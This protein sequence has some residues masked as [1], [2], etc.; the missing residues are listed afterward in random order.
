MYINRIFTTGNYGRQEL[1]LFTETDLDYCA[2]TGTVLGFNDIHIPT[3]LVNRSFSMKLG[4]SSGIAFWRYGLT[5]HR[6]INPYPAN[7]ENIVNL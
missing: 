4:D 1:K 2:I 5:C 7:V 3:L 6:R